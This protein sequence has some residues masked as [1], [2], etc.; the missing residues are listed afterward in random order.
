MA[1]G[2]SDILAALQNGV[3]SI[4]NLNT[5]LRNIF[6]QSTSLSTTAPAAG[7]VTFTSSEASAFLL[8]TT[9]SGGIYKLAAYPS[10]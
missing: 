1:I 10:T 7:T 6:P 4:N 2:L 9:S 5:S 3:T 8:V